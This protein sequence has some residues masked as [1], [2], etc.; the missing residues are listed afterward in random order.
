MSSGLYVIRDDVVTLNEVFVDS[1]CKRG[2]SGLSLA[3]DEPKPAARGVFLPRGEERGEKTALN[4]YVCS[5]KM[6]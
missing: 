1:G 2:S 3:L 4:K 5:Q 6:K